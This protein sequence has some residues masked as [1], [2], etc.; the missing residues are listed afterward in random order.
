MRLKILALA[1]EPLDLWKLATVWTHLQL[2][3]Q[4]PGTPA[5]ETKDW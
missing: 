2:R 5:A 1:S 4:Q 3:R